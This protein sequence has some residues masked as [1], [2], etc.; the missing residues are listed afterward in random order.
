[1]SIK[2]GILTVSLPAELSTVPPEAKE[3]ADVFGERIE[4]N[5]KD[6]EI[7]VKRI[8]AQAQTVKASIEATEELVKESVDCII[9]IIGSWVYV[10]MVVDATRYLR[11]PFILWA[12][13]DLVTGSLVGSCI[14]KGSLDEMGIKYKFVYGIPEDSEILN[15]VVKFARAGMVVNKMDG[16]KYGLFGGR[17]M[18]MYTGMPDLIQIKK[19]FG[20]ETV[21]IDE[22]WLVA[23]AKKINEN[24][25]QQFYE[26]FKA[27]Y[28]KITAPEDVINKSI[29]LYFALKEMIS[30]FAL[31]FVGLKCMPEIQGD[32]C[33]HC[34]SVALHL[35]EGIVAACEADTNAALT[36]EILHLLSG[37]SPGFGDVFELDMKKRNLRLVNCGTMSTEFA[38]NPKDID[39][40]QQYDFIATTGDGTGLCPAF[41][42][43]PGH[44]TIA[45][46]ARIDGN[47]VM[48]I[49]SGQ[50]YSEAKE[51]MKEARERWPHIFIKLDGDADGFLQNCRSNHL[52]WVYGDYKEELIEV[53]NLLKIRSILT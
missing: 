51:K 27:Y 50:A 7:V 25:I 31:D 20:V 21:H 36:M 40:V 46:L 43:K 45:R 24:K 39:W 14:T 5:L 23:R 16:M 13:P 4:K 30:E 2:I 29:R 33:S 32:Y 34:L 17:C 3:A 37:A 6:F 49:S 35:N 48:Q 9:Y 11:K 41:I 15:Q 19:I 12:M 47:F 22:F 18:Y 38:V 1:M 42:C 52:H 28:G 44:V 10:P 53:C 8:T 26:S